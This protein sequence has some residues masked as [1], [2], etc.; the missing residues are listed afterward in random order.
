MYVHAWNQ[1]HPL[2]QATAYHP[3]SHP[4]RGTHGTIVGVRDGSERA[5]AQGGVTVA[6]EA[7]NWLALVG[8]ASHR[9]E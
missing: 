4:P 8:Q 1:L 7:G 5:K 9:W 6:A 3:H 2:A